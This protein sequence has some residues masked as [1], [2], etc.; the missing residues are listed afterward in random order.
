MVGFLPK[1]AAGDREAKAISLLLLLIFITLTGYSPA[2]LS[3]IY[4]TDNEKILSDYG[5]TFV[6]A[7]KNTHNYRVWNSNKHPALAKINPK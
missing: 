2:Q 5:T 6:T 3:N 1:K 7:W 4:L